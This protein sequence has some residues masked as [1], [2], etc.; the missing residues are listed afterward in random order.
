MSQ[1][2]SQECLNVILEPTMIV[3]IRNKMDFHQMIAAGGSEKSFVSY[4]RSD[5]T[6]ST[7]QIVKYIM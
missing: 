7:W 6:I 2:K 4:D 1:L 3:R 5:V